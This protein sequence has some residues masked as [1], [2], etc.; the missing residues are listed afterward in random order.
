MAAS[1][2]APEHAPQ[3]EIHS[4]YPGTFMIPWHPTCRLGAMDTSLSR[5]PSGLLAIAVA[6]ELQGAWL[7]LLTSQQHHSC[8]VVPHVDAVCIAFLIQGA[9]QTVR[10]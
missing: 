5:L 8:H 4:N 7:S 6:T 3:L 9:I 10:S 2:T 1:G